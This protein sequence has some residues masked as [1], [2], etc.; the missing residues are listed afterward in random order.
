MSYSTQG[1]LDTNIILRWILGDIEDQTKKT[2]QLINSGKLLNVSA[3]VIAE[4]VYVL[5]AK[6]FTRAQ[7]KVIVERLS[8]QKNLCFMRS[9]VIPAIKL[10]S[11]HPSIS[12]V[13]ACLIYEATESYAEPLYTFDKKLANKDPKR[14]KLL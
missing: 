14:I 8:S 6:D 1:S 12:F 10:Y 7:I 5:E 13:D 2:D 9:V 3:L 11:Q 4:V